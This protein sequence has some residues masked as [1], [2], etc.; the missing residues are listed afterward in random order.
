MP[1]LRAA[2]VLGVGQAQQARS[3]QYAELIARN[4]ASRLILIGYQGQLAVR[5]LVG[6]FQ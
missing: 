6:Q 5:D 1:D 4:R 3:S 2:P